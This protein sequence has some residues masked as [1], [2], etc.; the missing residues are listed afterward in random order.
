MFKSWRLGRVLGFPVEINLSFLLLLAFV[1]LTWGGL[2][3][4]FVVLLSF[5]S[6]LLIAAVDFST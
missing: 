1:L 4:V 3:G 5:E 6:V 2:A